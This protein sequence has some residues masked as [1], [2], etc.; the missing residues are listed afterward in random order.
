ML[1]GAIINIVTAL[2][3]L[4]VFCWLRTWH[5]AVKFYDSKASA[6]LGDKDGPVGRALPGQQAADEDARGER[7]RELLLPA[8]A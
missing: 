7:G 4:L 1:T 8:L 2:I 5:K 6:R 3:A